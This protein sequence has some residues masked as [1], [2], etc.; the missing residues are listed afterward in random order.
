MG[1]ILM[2][3]GDSLAELSREHL[4]YVKQHYTTDQYAE[5]IRVSSA[6][7][8]EAADSASSGATQPGEIRDIMVL[9]INTVNGSKIRARF[10]DLMGGG[11][12][13]DA[14]AMIITAAILLNEEQNYFQCIYQHALPK[15]ALKG[16]VE[17]GVECGELVNAVRDVLY[18]GM[19][20][21]ANPV[22]WPLHLEKGFCDEVFGKL[23]V[24]GRAASFFTAMRAI[25]GADM[26]RIDKVQSQSLAFATAI[27]NKDVQCMDAIIKACGVM[28]AMLPIINKRGHKISPMYH[29]FMSILAESVNSEDLDA[30]M[31]DSMEAWKAV[32]TRVQTAARMSERP[33]G[34][35][36]A[37][38]RQD[39]YGLFAPYEASVWCGT[40]EPLDLL[41]ALVHAGGDCMP[42]GHGHELARLQRRQRRVALIAR[43]IF[44]D[45]HRYPPQ[46]LAAALQRM[47]DCG[48]VQ[49]AE[50]LR[51]AYADNPMQ[52]S[53]Y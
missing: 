7:M 33:Y 10:E 8:I 37:L 19:T 36:A 44:I 46:S 48:Q 47:R 14:R 25:K 27:S 26:S 45:T 21:G 29:C 41:S 11:A 31:P 38:F 43:V 49:L 30:S 40:D 1:A 22:A 53:A 39:K 28:V 5:F 32:L 15:V 34:N 9:W 23:M 13:D 3:L 51:V 4:K 6:C 16:F 18:E 50:D 17:G 42:P 52:C 35:F 2:N 20:I 24:S 12:F